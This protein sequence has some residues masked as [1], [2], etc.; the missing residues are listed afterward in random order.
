ML[1]WCVVICFDMYVILPLMF[2]I[3]LFL[4][5]AA[6]SICISTSLAAP[7]QTFVPYFVLCTC[8]CFLFCIILYYV[9]LEIKYQSINQ[10]TKGLC[11]FAICSND[12]IY[13]PAGPVCI[14]LYFVLFFLVPD[15]KLY[16]CA[17]ISDI[18]KP[19]VSKIL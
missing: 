13:I 16:F 7:N 15:A 6:S 8:T 4:S 14:R 3:L 19:F 18:R 11:E 17:A 5:T 1:S 12:M 10:S 9:L 2:F